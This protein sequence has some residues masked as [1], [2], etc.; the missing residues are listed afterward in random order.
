METTALN[1]RTI[2]IF[3]NDDL[4]QTWLE[5]FIIDR[6]IQ[7]MSIGT[8]EYYEDK[9]ALFHAFCEESSLLRIRARFA[10]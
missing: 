4:L 10:Q 2:N 9:L 7:N 5:A 3:G 1:Q 8:I 6:K